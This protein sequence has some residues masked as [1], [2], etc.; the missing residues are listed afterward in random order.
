[1]DAL[2]EDSWADCQGT[3]WLSH[4]LDGIGRPALEMAGDVISAL[5]SVQRNPGARWLL[6]LFP[7]SSLC[8]P[9]SNLA[10]KCF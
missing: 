9:T 3:P 8:T 4:C 6:L 10:S 7:T 1:M 5:G 2:T